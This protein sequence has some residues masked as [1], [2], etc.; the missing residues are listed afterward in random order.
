MSLTKERINEVLNAIKAVETKRQRFPDQSPTWSDVDMY[1]E[2]LQLMS[3]HL[4]EEFAKADAMVLKLRDDLDLITKQY[5]NLV[6][7]LRR[8]GDI[9]EAID[10]V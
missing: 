4:K 10:C 6:V 3:N 7:Q 5:Y 8:Q 2:A 1:R 9:H